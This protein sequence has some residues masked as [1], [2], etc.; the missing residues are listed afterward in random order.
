MGIHRQNQ[1]LSPKYETVI[2]QSSKLSSQ[3]TCLRDQRRDSAISRRNIPETTSSTDSTESG[4][5]KAAETESAQVSRKL[6]SH[7]LQVWL[8]A[9]RV[10]LDGS[11]LRD[12]RC[13]GL[14]RASGESNFGRAK[15][16]SNILE[17]HLHGRDVSGTTLLR[18]SKDMSTDSASR[19][20]EHPSARISGN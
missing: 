1:A 16:A 6:I 15:G 17:K 5:V 14:L 12:S 3:T 11:R 13:N 10:R 19:L 9:S 18:P 20:I 4:L 8:T 2:Q 7:K